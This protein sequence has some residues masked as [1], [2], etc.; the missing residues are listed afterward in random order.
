MEH[1][2]TQANLV[3]RL[4]ETVRHITTAHQ[5]AKNLYAH[6]L[7]PDFNAFD[8]IGPDEARLSK[9]LAWFLDRRQTHGHG[10]RFLRLFLNMLGE[11]AR[12]EECDHA[13]IRTEV[14]I[15]KGRLDILVSMDGLCVAIENKPWARER[16][17]QVADYL[18]H[19]DKYGAS[20]FVLI[21][22]TPKGE[23]PS[24]I[25]DEECKLRIQDKQ[26]HLWSYE[27]KILAWLAQCHAVCQADRVST[28]IDD[29]SR[30]IEAKFK[31]MRDRTMSDHLLEEIVA[32]HDKLAGAMQ[33]IF[34]ADDIRKRLL[35]SLRQ[36]LLARLPKHNVELTDAPSAQSG[37]SISY[38]EQSP[39]QF[40]LKFEYTQF[41]GLY[42]GI[43]RKDKNDQARGNEYEALVD[44][45]GA[46][47]QN[48]W[49]LWWRWVSPM[50]SLLPVSE[51]WFPRTVDR[52]LQG[53]PS[54]KN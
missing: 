1:P 54:R 26:L 53:E 2:D 41:R 7:A 45:I 40:E 27:E 34:L 32:S 19:F 11:N 36:Q 47:N 50:D 31:G 52:H 42:I 18:A 22:L 44:S 33:V 14:S 43:L 51:D 9:I 20:K 39:Y 12:T 46:G 28:F 6:R 3:Q 16:E 4:L 38:S 48:K 13:E 29:F 37:F 49:L 15:T 17:K 35:A 10:N 5:S 25:S 21:Y 8:F 24:S 23:P 30:Y